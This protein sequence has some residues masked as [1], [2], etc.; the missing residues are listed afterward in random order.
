VTGGTATESRILYVSR[1]QRLLVVLALNLALVAGLVIAGVTAHS[2]AV[3][4]AGTDYLLDAGGVAVAL[5]AIRLSAGQAGR[6]GSGDRPSTRNRARGGRGR[7]G[8]D[9]SGLPDR[10]GRYWS[11]C[12]AGSRTLA[13]RASGRTPARA[14]WS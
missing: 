12:R 9:R 2:L 1:T 8:W 14:S 10:E 7:A 6:R 11:S 3:L 5:L 13:S 4:A